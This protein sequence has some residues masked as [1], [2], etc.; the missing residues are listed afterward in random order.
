MASSTSDPQSTMAAANPD[1]YLIYGGPQAEASCQIELFPVQEDDYYNIHQIISNTAQHILPIRPT[2][3]VAPSAR[4]AAFLARKGRLGMSCEDG[5][6]AIRSHTIQREDPTNTHN[7]NHG[8][9]NR[10]NPLPGPSRTHSRTRAPS[11]SRNHP[12]RSLAA[13]ILPGRRPKTSRALPLHIQHKLQATM[14]RPRD[15][16]DLQR[17]VQG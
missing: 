13:T 17:R 8:P 5:Y 4:V 3:H 9:P 15:S 2:A 14:A 7:R 6:I 16:R 11:Q 12:L 10:R 1:Y